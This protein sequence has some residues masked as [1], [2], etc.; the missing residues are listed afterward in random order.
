MDYSY[1]IRKLK[2]FFGVPYATFAKRANLQV[3]T[4]EKYASGI[5]VKKMAPLTKEKLER[6]I[7]EYLDEMD[8]TL[9]EFIEIEFI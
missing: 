1:M 7:Y 2:A 9:E 6:A 5:G 4:V 8:L 3:K